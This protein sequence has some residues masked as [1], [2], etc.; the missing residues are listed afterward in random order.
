MSS[1]YK[2]K[3]WHAILANE[4]YVIR[5]IPNKTV[6]SQEME[7]VWGLVV[8]IREVIDQGFDIIICKHFLIT[9]LLSFLKQSAASTSVPE[10]SSIPA[11]FPKK[12]LDGLAAFSRS[13]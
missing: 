2:E 12:T 10:I 5:L 1:Q 8:S 13:F 11:H 9:Q 6:C 7:P 3:A 4:S